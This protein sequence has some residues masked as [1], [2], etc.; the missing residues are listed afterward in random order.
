LHHEARSGSIITTP[1]LHRGGNDNDNNK[2]NIDDG[3][4]DCYRYDYNETTIKCLYYQRYNNQLFYTSFS[5][6]FHNTFRKV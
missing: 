3:Y 4:I 2:N 6:S 1:L 5:V